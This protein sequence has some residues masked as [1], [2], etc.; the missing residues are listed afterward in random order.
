MKVYFEL[1]IGQ[2]TDLLCSPGT[3]KKIVNKVPTIRG[4]AAGITQIALSA[5]ASSAAGL[6]RAASARYPLGG[7]TACIGMCE[8]RW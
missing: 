1:A 4:L 6:R 3:R 5:T 8:R 7:T 2:D